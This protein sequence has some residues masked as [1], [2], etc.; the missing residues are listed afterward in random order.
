[1]R[2][3]VFVLVFCGLLALSRRGH[4]Q[5]QNRPFIKI[6]HIGAEDKPVF[7]AFICTQSS[8]LDEKL[9]LAPSYRAE[10]V[11]LVGKPEFAALLKFTKVYFASNLSAACG[12]DYGTFRITINDGEALHSIVIAPKDNALAFLNDLAIIVDSY[13]AATR[14]D[15]RLWDALLALRS[16]LAL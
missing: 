11:Y 15:P 2:L 3:S 9:E 14:K 13:Q 12:K 8:S 16:Q 5:D 10:S 4:A 6:S 1:M 7:G